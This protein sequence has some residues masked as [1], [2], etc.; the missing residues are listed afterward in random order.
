M[1]KLCRFLVGP[2]TVVASAASATK[3]KGLKK[4]G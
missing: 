2:G 3:R 1:A 4:Y